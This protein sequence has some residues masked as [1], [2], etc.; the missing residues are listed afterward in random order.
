MLVYSQDIIGTCDYIQYEIDG[1]E[2]IFKGTIHKSNCLMVV[3][4][5][6][7]HTLFF[8]EEKHAKNMLG[9]SKEFKGDNLL[10]S[11]TG[12]YDNFKLLHT[13]Q[14]EKLAILLLKAEHNVQLFSQDEWSKMGY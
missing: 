3:A 7:E 13:K 2:N 12:R 6:G 4:I 9:L 11:T 5:Q 1:N 8:S 14:N 10:K